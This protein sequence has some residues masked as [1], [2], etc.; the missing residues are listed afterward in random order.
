MILEVAILTIKDTLKAEFKSAF[1]AAESIICGMNGYVSHSLKQ[2]IEKS[3]QYIL[4][5]EWQT[6]EDHTI[7]F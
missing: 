4:L 6:L 3:N 5:V 1:M 7:G 2:C